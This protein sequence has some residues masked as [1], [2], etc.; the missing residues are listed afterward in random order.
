MKQLNK[1]FDKEIIK[2]TIGWDILNWSKSLSFL[3]EKVDLTKIDNALELGG[4]ESSAGYSLFLASKKIKTIFSNYDD[5]FENALKIHKKYAFSKYIQYEKIDAL[6]IPYK[7]HFDLVVFKSML[8]GIIRQQD[9][10]VG[11]I[12][13]NQIYNS[14]RKGGYLFFAENLKSTQL[15]SFL[16][17]K[18]THGRGEKPWRYLTLNQII[19]IAKSNFKD[20]DFTTKGFLGCFGYLESQKNILSIIDSIF[21]DKIIPNKYNYIAIFI[22][23]KN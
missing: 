18:I 14:L 3:C 7:N 22:C 15:H 5:S 21:L 12:V 13:F 11:N 2:D 23:K 17:K 10:N 8:G 16:R 4:G 1:K 6:N 9:L 19:A 20:I